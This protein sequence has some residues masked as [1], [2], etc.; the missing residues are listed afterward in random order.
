MLAKAQPCPRRRSLARTWAGRCCRGWLLLLS[1]VSKVGTFSS[2]ASFPQLSVLSASLFSAQCEALSP[3]EG[4]HFPWNCEDTS[5]YI[6][7][8]SWSRMELVTRSSCL[9]KFEIGVHCSGNFGPIC[10]ECCI[11][12]FYYDSEKVFWL[13]NRCNGDNALLRAG[14]LE[15]QKC[16]FLTQKAHVATQTHRILRG[17]EEILII[18]EKQSTSFCI[19]LCSQ[20]GCT[21]LL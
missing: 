15:I 20:P 12:V 13:G 1:A 19:S 2:V 5:F 9:L 8:C 18:P 3:A 17:E 4:Q 6:Q 10:C 21:H 7:V 14:L 16:F 11:N